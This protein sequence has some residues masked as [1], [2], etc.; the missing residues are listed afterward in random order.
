MPARFSLTLSNRLCCSPFGS[1]CIRLTPPTAVN[2]VRDI[3]KNHQDLIAGFAQFL[4]VNASVAYDGRD[5]PK[6]LADQLDD[7]VP[8]AAA[9]RLKMFP[10]STSE[11]GPAGNTTMADRLGLSFSDRLDELKFIEI[12]K[13]RLPRP[14]YKEYLKL[15]TLFSHEV[16]DRRGFLEQSKPFFG[17]GPGAKELRSM[18]RAVLRPRYKTR[19]FVMD[20]GLPAIILSER[21]PAMLEKE[22]EEEAE[23]KRELLLSSWLLHSRGCVLRIN[24]TA[25]APAGKPSVDLKNAKRN[26]HSYRKLPASV[27]STFP[28]FVTTPN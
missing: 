14:V 7:L 28:Y 16:I 24:P 2:R 4:P 26:G 19:D 3:F 5:P 8:G 11:V 6:R 21:P 12:L 9:K 13:D 10:A 25:F 20:S 27:G 15:M 18:L 23:D 22:E 1:S 17:K